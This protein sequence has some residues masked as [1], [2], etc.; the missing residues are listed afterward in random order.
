[1]DTLPFIII[2]LKTKAYTNLTSVVQNQLRCFPERWNLY[3]S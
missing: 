2:H 3:F 1:M